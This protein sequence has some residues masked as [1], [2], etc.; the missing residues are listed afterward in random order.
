MYIL[1]ERPHAVGN[2]LGMNVGVSDLLVEE[3]SHGALRL[4]G[5]LLRL[6]ADIKGGNLS[7]LLVGRQLTGHHTDEGRLASSVLAQ[8]H[9]NLTVRELTGVNL[10]LEALH[11]LLHVGI[12]IPEKKLTK[13]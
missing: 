4:G 5:N 9:D 10:H 13:S 8:Q 2:E 3:L 12:V 11:R 6:V 1:L 7:A